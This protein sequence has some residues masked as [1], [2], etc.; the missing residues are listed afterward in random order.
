MAP[1][2]TDPPAARTVLKVAMPIHQTGKKASL[3]GCGQARQTL[4]FKLATSQTRPP[5]RKFGQFQTSIV[6]LIQHLK[7]GKG[8]GEMSA[9]VMGLFKT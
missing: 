2:S 9:A 3:H 5:L 6:V 1:R 7:I 4:A 8:N